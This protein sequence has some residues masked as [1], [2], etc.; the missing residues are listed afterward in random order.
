MPLAPTLDTIGIIAREVEVLT[1]VAAVLLP[2]EKA[3]A[4]PP[5]IGTIHLVDEAFALADDE[6]RLA[7]TDVFKCL[8]RE[9]TARVRTTS[10]TELCNHE[11]AA[12]MMTWLTLYRVLQGTE[13]QSCLGAW[14]ADAKPTFGPA[15]SAGLEFVKKLDRTRI[16]ESVELREHLCE[17]L[18]AALASGDLLCIPSAPTIAPLKGSKA[19]DRNSDYYRRTL[20]LTTIA[21]VG[22]LPQVS[23]PVASASSAPTG[24]SI[25][26][27]RNNDLR[28]LDAAR[29]IWN[30][31]ERSRS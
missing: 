18:N 14:I 6:V 12:D 16:G 30:A 31:L 8:D 27:A 5:A 19:Y 25:L 2:L 13:M 20:S 28:L 17:R 21:G 15:P 22:R 4:T 23:M 11:R 1:R 24:L 3:V 9:T 7:L 26:A 10:L 29:T